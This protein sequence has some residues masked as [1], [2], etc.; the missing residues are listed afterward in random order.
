MNKL[1]ESKGLYIKRLMLKQL[2]I[3]KSSGKAMIINIVSIMR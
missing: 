2:P 1:E 3:R